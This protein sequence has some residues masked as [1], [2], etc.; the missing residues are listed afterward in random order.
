MWKGRPADGVLTHACDADEENRLGVAASR[1]FSRAAIF[2]RICESDSCD[3]G[4]ASACDDAR[5]WSPAPAPSEASSLPLRCSTSP[6]A[7]ALALLSSPP[8]ATLPVPLQSSAAPAL[9]SD[10]PPDIS[11]SSP[12]SLSSAAGL[13]SSLQ[14]L[15][16]TNKPF[17]GGPRAPSSPTHSSCSIASGSLWSDMG[18]ACAVMCGGGQGDERVS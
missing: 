9:P 15:V 13:N 4:A 8:A 10:S 11:S 3:G 2:S 5:S 14:Q 1:T 17:Q 12:S 7:L 18:G 16:S 6:C